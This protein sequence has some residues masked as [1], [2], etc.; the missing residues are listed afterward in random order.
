[1]IPNFFTKYP[2]P[3]KIPQ[4]MQKAIETLKKCKNKKEC[5]TKAYVIVTNRYHGH[6][7]TTYTRGYRLF[8]TNIDW[9]WKNKG[10]LHCNHMNFILRILLVKS[11]H[12]KES[13][14]QLKWTVVWYVTPHQYLRIKMNDGFIYIDPWGFDH[15]VPFGCYAFGFK[16]V[17]ANDSTK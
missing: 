13:E 15:D 12:F 4:S 11:G 9:L 3:R 7:L 5:L 17:C 16:K 10:F 14:I 8:Y 1:M 6:R 2:I